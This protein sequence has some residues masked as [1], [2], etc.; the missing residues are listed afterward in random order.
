VYAA[1]FTGL[2]WNNPTRRSLLDWFSQEYDG[3][4]PGDKGERDLQLSLGSTE[5]CTG[6]VEAMVRLLSWKD[7]EYASLGGKVWR[8]IRVTRKRGETMKEDP[9]ITGV[10]I[11]DL[12][13]TGAVHYFLHLDDDAQTD[14]SMAA[15]AMINGGESGLTYVQTIDGAKD[16]LPSYGITQEDF[17]KGTATKTD[18]VQL[19]KTGTAEACFVTGDTVVFDVG[20][21]GSARV[22]CER[23]DSESALGTRAEGKVEIP[24]ISR[25]FLHVEEMYE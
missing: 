7:G 5:L 23:T 15:R 9:L 1:T 25:M 11:R 21:G 24:G 12:C 20:Y 13:C 16:L 4:N 19:S 14:S 3:V 17:V 6:K 22:A 8:K 10:R 2:R 18:T